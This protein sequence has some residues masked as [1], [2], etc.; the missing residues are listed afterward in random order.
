MHIGQSR[1]TVASVGLIPRY[2]PFVSE[3]NGIRHLRHALAL[4]ER[5]IKFLPSYCVDPRK[6]K[7]EIMKKNQIEKD[8]GCSAAKIYEDKVNA[9][10]QESDVL[11]VW[12]AGV[13]TGEFIDC[14]AFI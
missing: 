12:F 2:L 14:Y 7:Q 8:E 10:S 4:D 5:R 13:H 11:E 1:D 6:K 3:N 9:E